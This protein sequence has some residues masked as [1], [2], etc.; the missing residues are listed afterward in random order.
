MTDLKHA[1]EALLFSSGRAM[2]E[3]AL[4][5][6]AQADPKEVRKV[7]NELHDDYAKR[8]GALKIFG[9]NG[10]WRMLI[11]DDCVEVVRRVVAD[12]EL[13]RPVM[14]TLAVV[15]FHYPK[16]L[17]SEVIKTRGAHAYEHIKELADAGFLTRVKE[18]R[19]FAIKL[20][21]KFFEYF[22]IEGADDIK[23]FFKGVEVPQVPEEQQKLGDMDIVSTDPDAPATEGSK[24][25]EGM[26]VVDVDENPFMSRHLGNK[27][28]VT[29]EEREEERGF[30][31]KIDDEIDSIANKNEAR[32]QDESFKFKVAADDEYKEGTIEEI[33]EQEK[34]TGETDY[35][36][37]LGES[38]EDSV[39]DEKSDESKVEAPSQEPVE[40][41]EEAPAEA[42]EEPAVEAPEPEAPVDDEQEKPTDESPDDEPTEAPETEAEEV[43]K[44]IREMHPEKKDTWDN[45][46]DDE[47]EKELDPVD[48]KKL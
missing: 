31:D 7:L 12:T 27:P 16:I 33:K 39:E 2:S 10:T 11:R 5:A 30:L 34:P 14:E 36:G 46:D 48:L 43:I 26:Q 37:E 19:S 44:E 3:E 8:E 1:I 18:G 35:V 28:E 6:V 42:T 21:E 38:I 23:E 40:S 4:A 20:T 22:D 32:D 15:A 47:D 13:T 24:D 25:L 9:E 17:Q 41:D 45:S 29:D